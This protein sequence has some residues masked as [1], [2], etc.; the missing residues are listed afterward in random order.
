MR[1][2]GW[3]EGKTEEEK[4]KGLLDVNYH[5]GTPKFGVN[6]RGTKGGRGNQKKGKEEE[7]WQKQRVSYIRRTEEQTQGRERLEN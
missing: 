6:N 4:N 1:I 3:N 5:R 7:K 2:K